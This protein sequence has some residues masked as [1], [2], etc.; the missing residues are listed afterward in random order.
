MERKKLLSIIQKFDNLSFNKF[1]N[2]TPT[3]NW[4]YAL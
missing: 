2:N 3:S 1:N 4:F